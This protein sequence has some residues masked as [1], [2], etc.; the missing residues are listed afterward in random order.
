MGAANSK[1]VFEEALVVLSSGRIQEESHLKSAVTAVAESP[2]SVDDIVNWLPLQRLRFLHDQFPDNF[3]RLLIKVV[4]AIEGYLEKAKESTATAISNASALK[5]AGEKNDQ[6]AALLA[7]D[8]DDVAEAGRILPALPIEDCRAL[9]NLVRILTRALPVLLEGSLDVKEGKHAVSGEEPLD[10]EAQQKRI[11]WTQA[12]LWDEQLATEDQTG[13]AAPYSEE[14]G[15]DKPEAENEQ[16]VADTSPSIKDMN[17]QSEVNPLKDAV[18]EEKQAVLVENTSESEEATTE[19]A[20]STTEPGTETPDVENGDEEG[21]GKVEVVASD[22][23]FTTEKADVT[24]EPGM[25]APDVEK[26]KEK[27]EGNGDEEGKGNGEVVASDGAFEGDVSETSQ[28]ACFNSKADDIQTGGDS[29]KVDISLP[30]TLPTILSD[31]VDLPFLD[32]VSTVLP[33]DDSNKVGLPLSDAVSKVAQTDPSPI[34]SPPPSAIRPS[35]TV[36]QAPSTAFAPWRVSGE[37]QTPEPSWKAPQPRL[38]SAPWR[39]AFEDET[40]SVNETWT[41]GTSSEQQSVPVSGPPS[42]PD[43]PNSENSNGTVGLSNGEI[44][45]DSVNKETSG[46]NDKPPAVSYGPD[47]L[48]DSTEERRSEGAPAKSDTALPNLQTTVQRLTESDE[49]AHMNGTSNDAVTS[50]SSTG[51]EMSQSKKEEAKAI[52]EEKGL[53]QPQLGKRIV[54]AAL[55]LLFLRNFTLPENA[56]SAVWVAGT[57]GYDFPPQILVSGM[58]ATRLELLRLLVVLSSEPMLLPPEGYMKTEKP[59]L[60]ELAER[61]SDKNPTVAYLF[62]SLLNFV[63][64]YRPGGNVLAYGKDIR[65]FLFDI[66]LQVLLALLDYHPSPN[67]LPSVTAAPSDNESIDHRVNEFQNLLASID[68]RADFDFL[69]DGLVANLAYAEETEASSLLQTRRSV[70]CL[71]ELLVYTWRLLVGNPAFLS[72]VGGGSPSTV[73]LSLRL[74]E[75]LLVIAFRCRTQDT[76]RDGALHVACFCLLVLT[77]CRPL[78]VLLNREAPPRLDAELGIQRGAYKLCYADCL[79]HVVFKT[80]FNGGARVVRLYT[81]LFTTLANV[82]PYVK[83][84]TPRSADHLVA[85]TVYLASPKMLFAREQNYIFLKYL[86]ESLNNLIQYQGGGNEALVYSICRKADVFYRLLA[87]DIPAAAADTVAAVATQEHERQQDMGKQSDE[88]PA[89]ANVGTETARANG[90]SI[91]TSNV[92]EDVGQEAKEVTG[93][94]LP[95]V[96]AAGPVLGKPWLTQEWMRQVKAELP[97]ATIDS[98]LTHVMPRLDTLHQ[99]HNQV[100]SLETIYEYLRTSTLVGVLPLPHPIFVRKYQPTDFTDLWFSSYLYGIIFLGQQEASILPIIDAR[101][102]RLFSVSGNVVSE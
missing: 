37:A 31:E 3:G 5:E 74:V 39:E 57:G 1:E 52:S 14:A 29:D 78:A 67:V 99:M 23:A 84:L 64:S 82:T 13:K 75:S 88:S 56:P 58:E 65:S 83:A 4:E 76:G 22:Q 7:L 93:D 87:L 24:T 38:L 86:L 101:R 72:Y 55:R 73:R 102:V 81:S 90:T 69:L 42:E 45:S 53:G 18:I 68:K 32:A 63:T 54:D 70:D 30:D 95:G 35:V 94:A 15:A 60:R 9:L 21:K 11:A 89:S 34:A 17:G 44:L 8:E 41:P 92:E 36:E 6:L 48:V 91:G 79:V 47:S 20:D 46:T 97:L 25:E 59:F 33:R 51:A 2:R 71:R 98:L 27:E 80:V 96:G 49:H 61:S 16:A 10:E 85:L 28:P 26:G 62:F 66:S 19:K 12:L 100:L 50:D 40:T 43:A 77:S